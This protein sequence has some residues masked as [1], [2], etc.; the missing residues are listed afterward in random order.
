MVHRVPDERVDAGPVIV[1]V[2][3]PF[4][5]ADTFEQFSERMHATEH[6][7]LVEALRRVLAEQSN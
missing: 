5:A 2:E 4:L 3:V 6:C 7:A 1:S